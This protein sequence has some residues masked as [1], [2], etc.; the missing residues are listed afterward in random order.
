MDE[1]I[2][3]GTVDTGREAR[4]ERARS[5][6]EER[7]NE[8][9]EQAA[10]GIVVSTA[11]GTVIACNPAFARMLGFASLD[12]AIGANMADLYA[13]PADRD[14]FVSEVRQKKQLESFRVR[15]CRRD[16]RAIE[17]VASVVGRYDQ[18]GA[19]VELRGYLID[20]SASVEAEA[21]VL[22]RERLFR[23]VFYDA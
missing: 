1:S 16:G 3:H 18:A 9:F 19:L 17:T 2:T 12:D 6:A 15:L 23:A 14:R 21:A 13:T 22:E 10:L 7:Y 20:I 4:I 5:A 11:A 8:L